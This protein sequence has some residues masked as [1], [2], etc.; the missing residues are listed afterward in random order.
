MELQEKIIRFK[1]YEPNVDMHIKITG[2]RPGEKLYEERL[3][4][5]EGLKKTPNKLISIGQPI[6]MDNKKFLKQLDEL[7]KEAYKN[8]PDIKDK[9]A[10]I[11]DTYHVDKSV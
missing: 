7:I 2:L 5:E 10:K 9:V 3:M 8:G 1:G 6:K 11:V 4:E